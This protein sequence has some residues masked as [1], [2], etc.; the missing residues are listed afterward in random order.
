MQIN[1]NVTCR[2]LTLSGPLVGRNKTFSFHNQ[3]Q[4][5]TIHHNVENK[6][7]DFLKFCGT[8]SLMDFKT[9]CTLLSTADS[10]CKWV[11]HFLVMILYSRC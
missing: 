5:S 6:K 7:Y 3:S 9:D 1:C 4:R 10:Y 8:I 2:M 11:N